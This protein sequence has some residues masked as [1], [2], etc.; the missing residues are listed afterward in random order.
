MTNLKVKLCAEGAEKWL[1]CSGSAF[2]EAKLTKENTFDKQ[3]RD[4]KI[5]GE[6][7]VPFLRKAFTEVKHQKTIKELDIN[8][9]MEP[10]GKSYKDFVME[11]FTHLER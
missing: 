3:K 9:E 10:F 2:L 8:Q 4:A 5:L 7:K 11:S 1:N 6:A